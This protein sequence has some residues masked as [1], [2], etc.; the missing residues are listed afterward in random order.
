MTNDGPMVTMLG[1]GGPHMSAE[2]YGSAI[3]IEAAGALVLMDCGPATTYKMLRHGL[4]PVNLSALLITHH[5]YDHTV[6][7]ANLLLAQWEACLGEFRPPSIIGP[8]PTARFVDQLV[9]PQGAFR[10]DIDARR[11]SPQSQFFYEYR[12][13]RLPRRPELVTDVREI[14]PRQ[15]AELPSG[16]SVTTARAQHV[17]PFL[18]SIAYRVEVAGRTIVYTGDTEYCED[19]IGLAEGADLLI[20]MCGSVEGIGEKPAQ[21]G[22]EGAGRTAAE[23]GVARVV[24][25]HTGP[26]I[27]Q[28]GQRERAVTEVARYFDGEIY[29]AHEGLRVSLGD[30]R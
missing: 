27:A 17:Q 7:V 22:T 30:E 2:R 3:A 18:E 8:P 21:M 24:L 20:S 4:S 13:G 25:T 6:D 29:F 26:R 15:E 28:P 5:H 11:H 10:P 9:G 12:G 19:V 14:Q 23:A 1:T 16:W